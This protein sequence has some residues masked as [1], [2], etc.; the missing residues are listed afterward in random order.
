MMALIIVAATRR[1]DV[2]ALAGRPRVWAVLVRLERRPPLGDARTSAG[3]MIKT[4]M[5]IGQTL[6]TGPGLLR[7]ST[8]PNKRD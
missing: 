4:S 5:L 3:T 2:E 7:L 8:R 6:L 1:P